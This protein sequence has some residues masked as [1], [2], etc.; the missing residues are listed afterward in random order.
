MALPLAARRPLFALKRQSP[1]DQA[2]RSWEK[3]GA[4]GVG[5]NCFTFRDMNFLFSA[6]HAKG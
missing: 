5:A 1:P 3:K 6:V 2:L 4:A